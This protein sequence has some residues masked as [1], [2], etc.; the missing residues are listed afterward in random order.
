MIAFQS[1]R[2]G[3]MEIW[4][5]SASDGTGQKQLTGLE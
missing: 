2:T 5:M 3:G 1:N 4:R